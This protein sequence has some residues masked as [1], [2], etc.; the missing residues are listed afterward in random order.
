MS[1]EP[2][3]NDLAKRVAKPSE[4]NPGELAPSR[5]VPS[6]LLDD[7]ETKID[8]QTSNNA[9][10]RGCAGRD[11]DPSEQ[12]DQPEDIARHLQA[13]AGF[14]LARARQLIRDY[15]AAAVNDAIR[16]LPYPPHVINPPGMITSHVQ[17]YRADAELPIAAPVAVDDSMDPEDIAIWDDLSP[18]ERAEKMKFTRDFN[19]RYPEER[20]K[21]QGIPV[22]YL[23]NF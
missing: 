11:E 5:P 4:K 3:A 10:A 13:H 7:D 8:M 12:H 1:S 9:R 19:R 22:K 21:N 23:R 15:G 17:D 18:N 20:A 16:E 6:P 14:R 2:L